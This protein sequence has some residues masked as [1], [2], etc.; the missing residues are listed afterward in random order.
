M[1]L[2][3]WGSALAALHLTT[4]APVSL[5]VSHLA[6]GCTLLADAW[7]GGAAHTVNDSSQ[8]LFNSLYP[9]SRPLQEAK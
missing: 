7:Q 6:A 5:A 4:Q 9:A 2:P 8:I 1:A 3:F